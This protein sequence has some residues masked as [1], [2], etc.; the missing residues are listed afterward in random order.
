MPSPSIPPTGPALG[1]T[2]TRP[3]P[4]CDFLGI[5]TATGTGGNGAGLERFLPPDRTTLCGYGRQALA[6]G[7]HR[8]G[9][10]AGDLILLPGFVCR[11]LIGA[12]RTVGSDVRFYDVDERL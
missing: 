4:D 10:G 1:L 9:I 11:D 7:L 3:L 6:I 8:L 5:F 12:V 2:T